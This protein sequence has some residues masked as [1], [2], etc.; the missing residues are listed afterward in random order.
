VEVSSHLRAN[1]VL[2]EVADRGAGVPPE[3]RGRIFGKFAMADSS[4]SRTKGGTGLGLSI[5]REIAQRHGGSIEFEDREGGGTVFRAVLPAYAFKAE[6]VVPQAGLPTV[7]HVD[8]D[9]DCLSVVASAFENRA[10]LVEI[11][12]MDEARRIVA[13]GRFEG[14]IID[15]GMRDELG[16]ELIPLLRARNPEIAVVLFSAIDDRHADADADAVLIKSRSTIDELVET[17]MDLI[18]AARVSAS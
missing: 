14:A 9:V 7:L 18:A 8:D 11:A 13:T 16:I 10:T 6:P 4:D 17:T 1:K 3:F 12:T 5:S 2:L 15:V